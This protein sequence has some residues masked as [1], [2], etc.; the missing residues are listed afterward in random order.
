MF[1]PTGHQNQEWK[2]GV[3]Q[4]HQDEAY[5]KQTL[6]ISDLVVDPPLLVDSA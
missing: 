5:H 3:L 6:Q 1:S 4:I 2:E